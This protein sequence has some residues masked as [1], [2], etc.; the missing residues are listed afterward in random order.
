MKKILGKYAASIVA[1]V[2]LVTIIIIIISAL[3]LFSGAVMILFGFQYDSIWNVIL[4]YIIAA[5][6][7]FPA[8][9]VAEA[10]PKVL[11][12]EFHIITLRQTKIIYL[13]LD[14]ICTAI[15]MAVVDFFMESISAPDIAILVAS[16]ILALI[17][18]KYIDEEVT[19]DKDS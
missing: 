15:G 2:I 11:Y 14:T 13:V 10:L 4:F 16:F 8:G 18:V 5:I 17:G 3:G 19:S 12:K 7:S 9:L 6:V 1:I